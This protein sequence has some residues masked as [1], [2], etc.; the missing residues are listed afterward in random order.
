MQSNMGIGDQQQGQWK[1]A[2]RR[3]T[4]GI[5]GALE[6]R[7]YAQQ[8]SRGVACAWQRVAGLGRGSADTGR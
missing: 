3:E 4:R 6:V 8:G 5:M 7:P 1:A 2:R